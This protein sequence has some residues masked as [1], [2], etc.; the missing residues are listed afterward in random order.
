VSEH[1]VTNQHYISQCLL[2]Y[3]ANSKGQVYEVMVE[4]RK[5][6][7]TNYKNSMVERF[8]YEHPELEK[9]R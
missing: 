7:L 8:T 1:Y 5:V 3:F 2:K 9:I 6:Y 4:A